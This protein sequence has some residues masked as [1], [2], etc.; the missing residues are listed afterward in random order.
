MRFLVL[1]ATVRVVFVLLAGVHPKLIMLLKVFPEKPDMP[2]R[3]T[4]VS[5]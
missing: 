2:S 3:K 1:K 4:L 5:I